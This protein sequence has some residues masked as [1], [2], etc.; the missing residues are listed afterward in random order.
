MQPIRVCVLTLT[1]ALA[2]MLWLGGCEE[3]E[4]TPPPPE[5]SINISVTPDSLDAGWDL[6]GPDGLAQGQGDTTLTDMTVGSYSITWANIVEWNSPPDSTQ[7]LTEGTS[8]TF[9]GNY[10]RILTPAVFDLVTVVGGSF[11]MGSPAGEPGRSQEE[12]QHQVNVSTFLLSVTEV[13]QNQWA[14]VR[15]TSPSWFTG[16]DD[17]PVE[18]VSWYDAIEFCNTLSDAEGLD[19]AYSGNRPDFLHNPDANGYRLPTEAEWE[20]A[21]RAGATGSLA[22]GDLTATGCNPDAILEQIGWY[23]GN[24]S[25]TAGETGQKETNA[26][27]LYDMHGGVWE[28]VWDWYMADYENLPPDDPVGPALGTFKVIR[29]GSWL[30]G[31]QRCRSANRQR[32]SPNSQSSD[33][34]F[35]IARNDTAQTKSWQGRS[36]PLPSQGSLQQG[37]AP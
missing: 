32:A 22:N 1:V 29:G 17:C 10:T 18:R 25:G 16:C 21:C 30:Y 28:W 11:T 34:G 37:G 33:L 19:R 20:Y 36:D 14:Q 27:G 9:P 24:T 35:R 31:A 8:I 4:L 12:V 5:Q 23:C 2:F 6:S 3:G 13:T 7:E 15:S 26:W